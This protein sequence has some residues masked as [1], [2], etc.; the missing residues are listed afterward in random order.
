MNA[1]LNTVKKKDFYI[2]LNASCP[3][4]CLHA[5]TDETNS[6][7]PHGQKRSAY[8]TRPFKKR[9]WVAFM[10]IN[11]SKL[12]KGNGELNMHGT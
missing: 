2:L 6:V 7:F 10:T 11:I 1:K 9:N 5:I 3:S 8:R 12:E 4:Q